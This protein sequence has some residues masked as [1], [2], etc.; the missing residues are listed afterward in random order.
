MKD[1]IKKLISELE[2]EIEKAKGLV[3]V[4]SHNPYIVKDNAGAC[5]CGELAASS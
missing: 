4:F 1:E 5:C 3:D 2:A